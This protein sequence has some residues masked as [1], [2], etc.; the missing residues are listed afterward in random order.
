MKFTFP[1][2]T[3]A[4]KH[5]S[6]VYMIMVWFC[7][8]IEVLLG[9]NVAFLVNDNLQIVARN[10]TEGVPFPA[11]SVIGASV[12][13][14]ISLAV[15]SAFTLGGMWTFSG[16]LDLYK[17]AEE[18]EH[19]QGTWGW[20]PRGLVVLLLLIIF[21]L[22]YTT[23][24]FRAAYFSEKGASSLF[25][26]FCGLII[27]PFVLGCIIHIIE[28]TP[29]DRRQTKAYNYAQQVATGDEERAVQYMTPQ[30]RDQYLTPGGR[31][32]ALANYYARVE[33]EQ[34]G[35]LQV[36]DEKAQ[37]KADRKAEKQRRKDEK[38]NPFLKV[39]PQQASPNDQQRGA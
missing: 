19:D 21:G 3:K 27:L 26:F 7:F 12:A 1:G 39:V 23:L 24:M 2:S 37:R 13:F 4:K 5:H 14:L 33:Q 31:E 22:D 36:N 34:E 20:W 10:M 16:F 6:L 17:D 28:N 38:R 32:D 9:L 25:L 29:R 30:E 8:M 18:Y 35:K 11:V 15:A